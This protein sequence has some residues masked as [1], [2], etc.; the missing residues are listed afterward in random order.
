MVAS[1]PTRCLKADLRD[2]DWWDGI[3]EDATVQAAQ[4]TGL[5]SFR[6]HCPWTVEQ[7]LDS[8][9][10]PPI[11]RSAMIDSKAVRQQHRWPTRRY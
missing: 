7:V 6:G 1:E 3:W 2:A 4:E 8:D 5:S 9:W 11:P 10:R